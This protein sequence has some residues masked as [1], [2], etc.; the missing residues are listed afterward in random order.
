MIRVLVVDDS[1]VF[2]NCLRNLLQN[3]TDITV[4]AEAEN[5]LAAIASV[6][7]YRPD[8]VLMDISMPIMGG[9]KA[10]HMIT[11]KHPQSRVIMLSMH[12]DDSVRT[13]ARE[14]GATRFFM[15][16]GQSKGLIEVIRST[17]R[18]V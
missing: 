16:D 18:D 1:A 8:I 5:G 15:K 9:I 7:E 10:T 6:E 11:S 14:A 3:Q 17:Y 12:S 13:A 2:R 4:V